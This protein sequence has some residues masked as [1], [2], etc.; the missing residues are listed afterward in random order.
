MQHST[1]AA[2]SDSGKHFAVKG[3]LE[4]SHAAELISEEDFKGLS[5]REFEFRR[6][7]SGGIEYFFRLGPTPALG[8]EPEGKPE[9]MA[10]ES[11]Q[12]AAEPAALPEPEVDKD[13]LIQ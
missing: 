11:S 12:S 6:T 1:E 2:H 3:V 7:A 10:Q 13:A 8:P 9:D 4:Q 5:L